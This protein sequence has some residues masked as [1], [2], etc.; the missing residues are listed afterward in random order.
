MLERIQII[1]KPLIPDEIQ[2]SF[3]IPKERSP[4]T[5]IKME[6][7]FIGRTD[8]LFYI[9]T[10]TLGSTERIGIIG[11]NGVG[12]STFIKTIL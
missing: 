2:F 11:E 12:K 4:E 1:E 6:D 9:R 8:P 3:D 7:A 5:L 10:A